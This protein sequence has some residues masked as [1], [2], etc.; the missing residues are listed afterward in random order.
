MNR[1]EIE[2]MVE[3]TKKIVH[4]SQDG[5]VDLLERY[6]SENAEVMGPNT[7]S[8]LTLDEIRSKCLM[9]MREERILTEGFTGE[10]DG[11]QTCRVKGKFVTVDLEGNVGCQMLCFRW[12]KG[13]DF[14]IT[15]IDAEIMDMNIFNPETMMLLCDDSGK[16]YYVEK[17]DLICAE[18]SEDH[19]C[20]DIIGYPGPITMD[21]SL[22]ELMDQA[23][24]ANLLLSRNHW[25]VNVD[26]IRRL[27]RYSM[28]MDNGEVLHID[29]EESE[30]LRNI[31]NGHENDRSKNPLNM[32]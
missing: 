14:K 7:N 15:K 19:I 16:Y 22:E 25:L 23:D 12:K 21:M 3:L 24:D 8:A 6:L 29:R 20:A 1:K 27:K 4:A 30:V 32:N 28:V 13:D 9:Y 17:T 11:F 26:H 2:N 31:E 10:Y 5:D 18:V